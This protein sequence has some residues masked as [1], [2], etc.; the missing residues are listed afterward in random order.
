ML[1][2]LREAAIIVCERT[3]LWRHVEPKYN[4]LPGVHEYAFNKPVA[5]DVHV[6]FDALMNDM[7]LQR[8]TLE[9][10]LEAYPAWAN[11]YSGEDPSVVWSLTPPTPFNTHEFSEDVFNPASTYSLPSSIVAEG[12]EP[13]AICQ[14]TPDK[15]IVLPLPDADK[16]YTLRMFY[17]L[18]PRRDATG[19]DE[20]VSYELED[21]IVH[22]A[23]QRLLVMPNVAWGDRELASY[24]G[25]QALFVTTER[26]ARANLSNFRGVMTARAPRFA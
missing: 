1:Q 17:A 21:A 3:L 11:L 12:S 2:A 6:V 9:Q 16:T 10:A 4:L 23:L 26:R 19:M 13:R 8:L 15:Y 20:A 22:A 18:K 7:P 14:I 24:H 25:K 5:A